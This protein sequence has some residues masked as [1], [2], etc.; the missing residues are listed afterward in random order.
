MESAPTMNAHGERNGVK[1]VGAVH[2]N[3]TDINNVEDM[4]CFTAVSFFLIAWSP[5]S[6]VLLL[7]TFEFNFKRDV[8]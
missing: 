5:L 4:Y 3:R 8:C 7:E 1:G 2:Q 6:I